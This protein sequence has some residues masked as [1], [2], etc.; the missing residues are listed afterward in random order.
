MPK[1]SGK[2][3]LITGASMGIGEAIARLFAQEGARLALAARSADKL[4]PLAA[5]LGPNAFPI[6]TDITDPAQVRRMVD[7]TVE[8]FGRLDILV[9]NAGVGMYAPVAEMQPE[10]FEKVVATNWLGPVYAIQSAVPHMRKQGGGQIINISS[11]AGKI[12]I[13]WMGAY[14]STKFA[15]NALSDSLRLELARDRIHVLSVCP[16]RIATPFGRNAFRDPRFRPLPPTGISA[17][18]VARAV[19]RASLSGKR[20]IVVPA[21]NRLFAWFRFFFPRLTDAMLL[22]YL[23]GRTSEPRP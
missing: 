1:L 19:L 12:A 3:V 6:P 5:S 23:R 14:C 20:E 17:E 4:E 16:G 21:S 18:R 9:N 13:P 15:L 7:A 11:V 8:R 10:Q 22:S 2:V